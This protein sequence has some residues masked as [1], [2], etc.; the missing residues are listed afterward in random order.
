LDSKKEICHITSLSGISNEAE[1]FM[2]KSVV[3]GIFKE[4]RYLLEMESNVDRVAY[5]VDGGPSNAHM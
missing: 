2:N 5:K 4:G 3:E 1:S